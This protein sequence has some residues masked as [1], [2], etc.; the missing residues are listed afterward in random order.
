MIRRDHRNSTYGFTLIEL[1]IS[2][3]LIS[4]FSILVTQI[5]I[6]TSKGLSD[7][8]NKAIEVQGAIRFANFVKYDFASSKEIY[9][10]SNTPPSTSDSIR[11]TSFDSLRNVWDLPL[12]SGSK[13][14]VRGLFTILINEIPYNSAAQVSTWI[15]P[16]NLAVGY[17]IRQN[18][19]Q[20]ARL[21]APLPFELWRVICSGGVPGS[22]Q[23]MLSLGNGTSI[24]EVSNCDSYLV[25]NRWSPSASSSYCDVPTSANTDFY[26]FKIPYLGKN[27]TINR[28]NSSE[29]RILRSRIDK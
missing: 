2:T 9:M 14:Y 1:L 29:F 3:L 12:P 19:Y 17:E 10:H 18:T 5:T 26:T 27:V 4:L 28:L 23:K 21:S 13:P 22:A 6:Q 15:N 11:C 7:V 20:G 24:L 25:M 8:T 16:L